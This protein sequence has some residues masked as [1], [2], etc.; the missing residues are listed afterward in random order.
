MSVAQITPTQL[1]ERLDS[2]TGP[3]LLL[4]VREPLERAHC[5]IP[6]S[7]HIPMQQV[8][9]RLAELPIE[10]DIVVFCHHGMRSMQVANF[11]DQRGYA[12]V[13]NLS[14]GIDAWSTEADPSVPR[15]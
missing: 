12:R 6:G 3:L 7:L 15:Y 9:S 8:P 1:R 11:L 10:A 13:S 2:A 4:D 14:G 5:H